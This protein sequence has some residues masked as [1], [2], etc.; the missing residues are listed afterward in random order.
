MAD[1]Y[2][3]LTQ[4]GYTQTTGVQWKAVFAVVCG[5]LCKEAATDY[6]GF[7]ESRTQNDG[8]P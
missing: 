1:F 8:R 4:L 6:S 3:V 2:R 5:Y 7:V